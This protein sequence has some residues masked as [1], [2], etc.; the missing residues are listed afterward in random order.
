MAHPEDERAP[1]EEPT[2]DPATETSTEEKSDREE[3]GPTAPDSP[4]GQP[5]T[6]PGTRETEQFEPHE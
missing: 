2:A 1:E 5:D 6:A 4:G 3:G